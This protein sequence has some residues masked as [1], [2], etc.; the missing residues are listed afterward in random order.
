MIKSENQELAYLLFQAVDGRWIKGA[1]DEVRLTIEFILERLTT[2]LQD[3]QGKVEKSPSMKQL[4]LLL[5]PLEE[6]IVAVGMRDVWRPKL[7]EI[8][9][10][11]QPIFP[12]DRVP[13]CNPPNSLLESYL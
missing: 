3:N 8:I 11:M 9:K 2:F 1:D 13:K 10:G 7:L 6:L 5:K 4:V 12:A